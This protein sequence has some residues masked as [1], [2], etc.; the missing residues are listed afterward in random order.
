MQRS[1]GVIKELLLRWVLPAF[2]LI[3][4]WQIVAGVVDKDFLV[5]Y[6]WTVLMRLGELAPNAD[7]WLTIIS[8]FFRILLGFLAGM[9]CGTLIAWAMHVSKIVS[10][11]MAPVMKI[12]KTVPVV[13]FVLILLLWLDSIFLP[14]VVSAIMV[15]PIAWANASSGLKEVQKDHLDMA[16]VYHLNFLTRLRAIYL[17]SL[18]PYLLSA[19]V[20]GVGLAWKS[21]VT[22]EVLALPLMS[23]GAKIYNA[24]IYLESPDIFAW[25][26]VIVVVS[27]L[28]E[29]TIIAL[30]KKLFGG[31]EVRDKV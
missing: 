11:V 9:I 25:T 14:I 15:T 13:S 17:P 20:A 3:G 19:V 24:K 26:I 21:G 12:L 27:I 29:K 22:A 18:K 10:Y 7:F 31:G 1:G 6:P 4:L 16:Q 28:F 5:P 30:F 2:L 23:I 8:T